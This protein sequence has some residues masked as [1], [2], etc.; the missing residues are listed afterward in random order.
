MSY[1][2]DNFSQ[3]EATSTSTV[4]ITGAGLIGFLPSGTGAVATTVQQALREQR[5]VFLFMTSVQIADVQAGTLALDVTAACQAAHTQWPDP[6]YPP[7][8]YR[9][10]SSVILPNVSHPRGAGSG[11]EAS[12]S[13][14]SKI[15]YNGTTGWA[16]DFQNVADNTKFYGSFSF[17]KLFISCPNIPAGS[18]AGGAIKIGS[19]DTGN[20][21]TYGS[22][23]KVTVGKD[24]W[25]TGP[26]GATAGGIGVYLIKCFDSKVEAYIAGF[27]YGVW[28]YG[29]DICSISESCRLQSNRTNVRWTVNGTNSGGLLIGHTDLLAA[30]LVSVHLEGVIAPAMYGAYVETDS[31]NGAANTSQTGTITQADLS[32]TVTG[33]GTTF[34]TQL[35]DSAFGGDKKRCLIK[36]GSQYRQ[37]TAVANDTSLT[38][39]TPF[40]NSFSGQAWSIVTGIGVL[41]SSATNITSVGN[42]IDITSTAGA[43]PRGYYSACTF[44]R[45]E[46]AAG[47]STSQGPLIFAGNSPAMFANAW[48]GGVQNN[49]NDAQ[50][51]THWYRSPTDGSRQ[52][53]ILQELLA[54]ETLRPAIVY[55]YRFWFEND[56]AGK[57]FTPIGTGADANSKPC[58]YV[59]IAGASGDLSAK[60]P[61]RLLDKYVRIRF[62]A[63]ALSVDSFISWF[64]GATLGAS[65]AALS[66]YTLATAGGWTEFEYYGA[67]PTTANPYLTITKNTTNVQWEFVSIQVVALGDSVP[68]ALAGATAGAWTNLIAATTIGPQ[69]LIGTGSPE[70][71]VFGSPGDVFQQTDGVYG[72]TL[73]LK[74][75]GSVTNTGWNP[76]LTNRVSAD[77]G[78]AIATL[79]AGTSEQTNRWATPLTAN[80]AVTLSTT[81]VWNGAK[82]HIVRTAA[83]TGASTLDVGTG[84]L[85][86]LA[87][88]QY[89]DVEYNGSAWMLTGFGSL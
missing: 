55:D 51:G 65:T 83:A 46:D 73:W 35:A 44:S 39:D 79:T 6:Y 41:A 27:N 24:C 42:R 59:A 19:T 30:N 68:R 4:S 14:R 87:V 69:T 57:V 85:K 17:D 78:D 67:G 64:A 28:G 22:I 81:G 52:R 74:Q 45:L 1:L 43:V 5:S 60:L 50:P 34:L 88:G 80:R 76:A 11:Q 61:A 82:F 25:I 75:T 7:G 32:T 49:L 15:V 33:S 63:K 62:R 31:T 37:V 12:L 23:W 77:K 2:D 26:G 13:R 40:L 47:T 29:S 70:G 16:F 21:S 38:V 66:T 36:V 56:G 3:L 53:T 84:P 20:F 48:A 86:S 72:T 9:F 58:I 18:V 54:Y 8:D 10:D 89:C 71:V